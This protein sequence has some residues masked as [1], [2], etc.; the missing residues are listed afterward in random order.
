MQDERE[1]RD[2]ARKL[3]TVRLE[4]ASAGV[5]SRSR[6]EEQDVTGQEMKDLGGG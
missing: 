3:E 1:K 5:R 2:E 6:T 4:E